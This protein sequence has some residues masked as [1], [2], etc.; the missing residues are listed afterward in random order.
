MLNPLQLLLCIIKRDLTP[1]T[2]RRNQKEILKRHTLRRRTPRQLYALALA[3]EESDRIPQLHGRKLNAHAGAR[4]NAKRMEC[5]FR[6]GGRGFGGGFFS[7]DP[8]GGVEA[9]RSL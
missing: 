4:T 6:V 7:A 5:G 1:M 2:L 8:A 9:R 3:E